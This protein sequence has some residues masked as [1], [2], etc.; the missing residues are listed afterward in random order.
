[1]TTR[2]RGAL[3]CALVAASLIAC[4]KS[5]K[6]EEAGSTEA[7]AAQP[8]PPPSTPVNATELP[9]EKI[10]AFVNPNKAPVYAGPTGSVE[11]TVTITG[12]PP[13]EVKGLDFS[14]C[15]AGRDVYGKLFRVGSTQST[16]ARTLGDALVAVTGYAG[17]IP[18]R[19]IAKRVTFDNCAF[20]TRTIDLTIG[21]KLEVVNNSMKLIAPSLAQAPL[22][23]LML[24]AQNTAPVNVYP[25][26]PGYF[27]VVDR[28]ELS[29]LRG[30]LYAL[31]QP[32]HTVT[33][34]DGHYRIDGIPVGKATL[35]ARLP[36]IRKETSRE[37][38]VHANR[39]QTVDL[40]IV[41]TAATDVPTQPVPKPNSM[42]IP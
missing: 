5:G 30:D 27:T 25:V 17:F 16:G 40:S 11:G 10:E 29:Y 28:M 35:N 38:E 36:T 9:L 39:V 26:K 2:P 21:Q 33:T 32:L 24:A 42:P 4:G 12:D 6:G 1:M 23:A 41:F 15:P 14:K 19:N 20:S 31:L 3:L 22:P 37:I 13:P 18:E 34:I 7:Y 8:P